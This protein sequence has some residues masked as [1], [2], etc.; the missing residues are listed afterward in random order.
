MRPAV[1]R[2]WDQHGFVPGKDGLAEGHGSRAEVLRTKG[3]RPLD[4]VGLVGKGFGDLAVG[5]TE[6]T[7]I[8]RKLAF[9]ALRKLGSTYHGLWV[10]IRSGSG[11]PLSHHHARRAGERAVMARQTWLVRAHCPSGILLVGS[12]RNQA[13]VSWEY[14]LATL[15]HSLISTSDVKVVMVMSP[16]MG[17][18]FQVMAVAVFRSARGREEER[19]AK[20]SL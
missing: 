15:G 16:G 2:S 11:I 3:V 5:I 12:D 14:A 10:C 1:N 8:L 20:G 4:T 7:T 13:R 18:M 17:E 9:T 19:S 6:Q